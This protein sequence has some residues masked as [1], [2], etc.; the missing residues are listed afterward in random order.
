M[1]ARGGMVGA[2]GAAGAITYQ[3]PSCLLSGTY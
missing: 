3:A 1:L 2:A